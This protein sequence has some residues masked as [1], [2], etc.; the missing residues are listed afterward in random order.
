MK[1]KLL[2]TKTSK[3][4]HRPTLLISKVIPNNITTAFQ[5]SHDC[6][7]ALILQCATQCCD[8]KQPQ[9]RCQKLAGWSATLSYPKGPHVAMLKCEGTW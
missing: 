2:F 7:K 1:Y 5:I 6:R 3:N 9:I 8:H 4:S